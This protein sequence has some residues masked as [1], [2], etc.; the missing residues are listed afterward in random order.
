MKP[1]QQGKSGGCTASYPYLCIGRQLDRDV[2]RHIQIDIDKNVE[3]DRA[4]ETD[5]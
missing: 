1:Y 4:R 3:I 2:R 5:I